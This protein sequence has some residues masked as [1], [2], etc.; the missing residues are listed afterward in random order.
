MPRNC[1]GDC[2][3]CTSGTFF[4]Y[5]RLCQP[6]V[7]LRCPHKDK[8][9]KEFE[10]TL[11]NNWS[12]IQLINIPIFI[13]V[14]YVLWQSFLEAPGVF[15]KTMCIIKF[16]APSSFAL[17]LWVMVTKRHRLEEFMVIHG[18]YKLARELHLPKLYTATDLKRFNFVNNAA[19][20]LQ[21][22]PTVMFAMYTSLK[23][24]KTSQYSFWL[25]EFLM[26]VTTANILIFYWYLYYLGYRYCG[27]C[28]KNELRFVR[29]VLFNIIINIFNPAG[30]CVL[31]N[32]NVMRMPKTCRSIRDFP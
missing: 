29:R 13:W 15:E 3:N 20:W 14:M 22:I 32:K 10:I 16:V 25:I 6:V 19:V 30:Y 23:A 21:L 18:Y 2:L 17:P 1:Q 27:M 8:N 24:I 26:T 4:R 5:M 12:N 28:F 11:S 31:P 7:Q 9:V